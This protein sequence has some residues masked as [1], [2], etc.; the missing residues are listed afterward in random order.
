MMFW[1]HSFWLVLFL[2]PFWIVVWVQ[3]WFR[4]RS[5]GGSFHVFFSYCMSIFFYFNVDG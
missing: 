3:L 2:L 5:R 4:V 1:K